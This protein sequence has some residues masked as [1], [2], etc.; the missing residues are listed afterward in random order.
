MVETIALL[1]I[2]IILG[3]DDLIRRNILLW[4]SRSRFGLLLLGLIGAP[5]ANNEDSVFLITAA[6]AFTLQTLVTLWS[7]KTALKGP[8]LLVLQSSVLTR[9][10]E[11]DLSPT[12]ILLSLH[13]WH[14]FDL[15]GT[16]T[17][18]PRLTRNTTRI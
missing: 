1:L 6:Y 18:V 15:P 10:L 17:M 4:A 7:L 11:M 12:A 2:E 13:V 5:L 8:R 16:P 14:A 3:L 9:L